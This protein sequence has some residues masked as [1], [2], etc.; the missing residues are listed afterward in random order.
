MVGG[1]LTRE[2]TADPGTLD[3]IQ[4]VLDRCWAQHAYVPERIRSEV[5]IAVAEIAA[6]ILEHARAVSLTLHLQVRQDDV[7]VE[8]VDGG[9]AA[10]VDLAAARMPT[11]LAESGRGLALAQS[12]LAGLS[13]WRDGA[14]NHW[15]LVS[16]TFSTGQVHG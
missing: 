1:R 7:V 12:V 10:V 14:G 9:E 6:N 8:F 4:G 15:R 5:G 13:Y 11:P 3:D 2:L 16:K